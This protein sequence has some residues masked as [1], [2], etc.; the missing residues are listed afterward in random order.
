MPL[1]LLSP[2]AVEPVTLAEAKAHLRIDHSDDEAV[3]DG[4]IVAARDMVEAATG[5]ALISQT[6]RLDLAGFPA[7]DGAIDLPRPPTASVTSIAYTDAAG[8]TQTITPSDYSLSAGAGPRAAAAQ[9]VPAYGIYWPAT[10]DQANAVRI[11][12]VAGYGATGAAVPAALIAAIKLHL[13]DLYANRE[14]SGAVEMLPNP[15][16]DRLLA[17]YRVAWWA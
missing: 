14:G 7:C 17:A 12:F 6:W 13:G 16:I 2:P 8:A 10:R 5:R 4:F 1:I 11:T 15:T 3:I 9:I